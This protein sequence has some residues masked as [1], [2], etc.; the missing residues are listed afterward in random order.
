MCDPWGLLI[1]E[2]TDLVVLLGG[3]VDGRP[4]CP[5]KAL[6]PPKCPFKYENSA[7]GLKSALGGG[8]RVPSQPPPVSTGPTAD[9]TSL[10]ALLTLF[11]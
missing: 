10:N 5:P 9:S 11:Y 6:P 2:A 4:S 1:S 3:H 8:G 7:E